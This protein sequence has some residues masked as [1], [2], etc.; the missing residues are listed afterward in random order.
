MI[1]ITGPA[2]IVKSVMAAFVLLCLWRCDAKDNSKEMRLQNMEHRIYRIKDSLRHEYFHN[3]PESKTV[4]QSFA[5]PPGWNEQNRETRQK[6]VQF[7]KF[8]R[9]ILSDSVVISDLKP[10]HRIE[11]YRLRYWL[12]HQIA[13]SAYDQFKPSLNPF[14]GFHLRVP[15][16]LLY[17]IKVTTP[18]D[19]SGYIKQ[20]SAIPDYFDVRLEDLKREGYQSFKLPETAIAMVTAQNDRIIRGFPFN[21]GDDT[22][23]I[24][25][26]FE[27]KLRR[28]YT[29]DSL[30]QLYRQQGVR[31]FRQVIMPAYKSL[32]LYIKEIKAGQDSNTQGTHKE[33]L[34]DLIREYL[35]QI[36]DHPVE[37]ERL[38]DQANRKVAAIHDE[39]RL[40]RTKSGF[41]D[42]FPN[43]LKYLSKQSDTLLYINS[44]VDSL[45]S[46][47]HKGIPEQACA[48]VQN[49]LSTNMEIGNFYPLQGELKNFT[50]LAPE[51]ISMKNESAFSST[52]SLLTDNMP[53]DIINAYQCIYLL[54][55][56]T[57]I[58]PKEVKDHWMLKTEPYTQLQTALAMHWL[59][60]FIEH[61]HSDQA[62]WYRDWLI[63]EL[64]LSCAAVAD[65]GINYYDWDS[66]TAKIYYQKNAVFG[67]TD[68]DAWVNFHFSFPGMFSTLLAARN[69]I[70]DVDN[71]LETSGDT[72][73]FTALIT[74][75]L[76]SPELSDE[77]LLELII[78]E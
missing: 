34:R 51:L 7:W 9:K 56:Q 39:L 61:H 42:S 43:F 22:S 8:M 13:L 41:D 38:F 30:R 65:M 17:Q 49:F 68:L 76:I 47:Q 29:N 19:F 25:G 16:N 2:A 21:P 6:E 69:T 59:Q 37:V 46:T 45:Q 33:A 70:N 57:V 73:R 36:D 60:R 23:A 11:Y 4:S 24:F 3:R 31:V 40:V 48:V 75:G 62:D 63:F 50:L 66:N 54:I 44:S 78:P 52:M 26:D 20:L 15:Y 28:V 10:Q 58:S 5:V 53:A 35:N 72:E 74:Y 27:Q 12:D 67:S 71:L 32:N 77:Q 1:H 18:D 14:N 64:L 55:Y